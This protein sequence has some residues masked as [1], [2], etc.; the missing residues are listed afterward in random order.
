[1]KILEC[2]E[3]IV[4]GGNEVSIKN[5]IRLKGREYLRSFNNRSFTNELALDTFTGDA[6]FTGDIET[7]KAEVTTAVVEMG[8]DSDRTQKLLNEALN[9]LEKDV[10][11]VETRVE[12]RKLARLI[13]IAMP[14][15][16]WA[17]LDAHGD[18]SDTIN[19]LITSAINSS[20]KS[21][22]NK[23]KLAWRGIVYDK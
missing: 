18:Y 3:S 13:S 20:K 22:Q 5:D 8:G 7:F 12:T 16:N 21:S 14:P 9:D 11:K 4:C 15:K 1:M 17:W 2:A 19:K 10:T 23:E 6:S